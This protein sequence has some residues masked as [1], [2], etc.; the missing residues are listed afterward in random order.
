MNLLQLLRLSVVTPQSKSEIKTR[1]IPHL[2]SLGKKTSRQGSMQVDRLVPG[3]GQG[4]TLQGSVAIYRLVSCKHIWRRERML[5]ERLFISKEAEESVPWAVLS[6]CRCVDHSLC[7][8][9]GPPSLLELLIA[10]ASLVRTELWSMS[11]VAVT[12]LKGWAV[13]SSQIRDGAPFCL[14]LAGSFFTPEPQETQEGLL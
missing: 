1:R 9:A 2:S 11:S 7:R 13:G 3:G 4:W 6:L 10:V 14:L 12:R 8:R 5:Q